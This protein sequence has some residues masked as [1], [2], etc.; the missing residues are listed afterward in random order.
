MYFFYSQNNFYGGQHG[1]GPHSDDAA[2]RETALQSTLWYERLVRMGLL[3]GLRFFKACGDL[4][5]LSRLLSKALKPCVRYTRVLF[6]CWGVRSSQRFPTFTLRAQRFTLRLIPEL[7]IEIPELH[8][9]IRDFHTEIS[10]LSRLHTEIFGFH[11]S[12]ICV[13]LGRY[14]SNW[15][16]RSFATSSSFRAC[17]TWMLVLQLWT[18]MNLHQKGILES[19]VK[20]MEAYS[21]L[22]LPFL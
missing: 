22:P 18:W 13:F 15:S 16:C 2:G 19:K 7:H 5:D 11:I 14:P 21:P 4:S 12:L 20:S 3:L 8:T 1:A 10:G 17:C 9:E 6:A